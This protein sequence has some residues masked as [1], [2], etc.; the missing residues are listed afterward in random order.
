MITKTGKFHIK[1]LP[2]NGITD[3]GINWVIESLLGTFNI[4]LFIG[5]R[6]LVK[7]IIRLLGSDVFWPKV[8]PLS[9]AYYSSLLYGFIEV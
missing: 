4:I 1:W 8:I 9:G 6:N 7:G 2:L 3:N 5:K